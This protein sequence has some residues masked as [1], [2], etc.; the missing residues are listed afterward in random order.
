[1]L[2]ESHTKGAV[3]LIYVNSSLITWSNLGREIT[4]KKKNYIDIATSDYIQNES[5]LILSG[6]NC[7]FK[8]DY[9]WRFCS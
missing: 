7:P 1:M 4:F 8:Q 9:T 2:D 5:N 3:W 6:S